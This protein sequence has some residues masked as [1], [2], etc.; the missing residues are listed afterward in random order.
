MPAYDSPVILNAVTCARGG[1]RAVKLADVGEFGLIDRIAR[2]VYTAPDA[3]LDFQDDAA[4]WPAAPATPGGRLVATTDAL[5]ED[6]DFR[7][8][9]FGWED[10]GWK[11]LAV[12]L[13][14]VA[15][16]GGVPRAALVTL[17]LP[18]GCAAEDVAAFY[19]GMSALAREARTP[20]IGGDLSASAQVMVNVTVIGEVE[21]NERTLRRASARVGDEIAVTGVLG[22]A[23]A[24]LALLER[25]GTAPEPYAARF[26]AAQRRPA[27][28]LR[29]G[30]ALVDA[31]VRCGMDVSDGLAAD[32]R[33]LCAAS[34]VAAE[35]ALA[36]VPT[37]PALP[38]VLG[39]ACQRRATAGGEDFEL[40]FTAPPGVMQR[41]RDALESGGLAKSTVIGR[42]VAGRAGT[43]T[44]RDERGNAA[45]LPREGFDH[46]DAA[47]ARPVSGE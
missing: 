2:S 1:S 30:R 4:L 34:G 25:G 18:A 21:S 43:L 22:S 40:L 44:A 36:A 5:V 29:E 9:T 11:A 16:M 8:R 47:A 20:I 6:V 41:A 15:A 38:A 32:L 45:P 35:I 3:A 10:I 37:D 7:L 27:P 46:F 33:K 42:I 12:S 19:R 13:S 14:D 23:A 17:C 28:R 24:G 31:G 39:E 26:M